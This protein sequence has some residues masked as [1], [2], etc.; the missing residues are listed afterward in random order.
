MLEAVQIGRRDFAP[1]ARRQQR[2]QVEECVGGCLGQFRQNLADVQRVGH[3][4]VVG[5]RQRLRCKEN[6]NSGACQ[7]LWQ[8]PSLMRFTEAGEQAADEPVHEPADLQRR[9]DRLQEL[10]RRRE[11]LFDLLERQP[12]GRLVPRD[13]SQERHLFERSV[14]YDLPGIFLQESR[15]RSLARRRLDHWLVP[16]AARHAANHLP[17]LQP[18][19]LDLRVLPDNLSEISL[20]GKKE[21]GSERPS[22]NWRAFFIAIRMSIHLRFT[23]RRHFTNTVSFVLGH[24]FIFAI[25]STDWTGVSSMV[26][27]VYGEPDIATT[28]LTIERGTLEA[29]K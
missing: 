4:Q 3:V 1:S 2:R 6:I 8:W 9:R 17:A 15:Q 26:F 18:L 24:P 27:I 28:P 19:N 5:E 20:R 16:G 12:V 11:N 7:A 13:A 22:G 14:I 21:N 23:S 25:S 29:V 10:R